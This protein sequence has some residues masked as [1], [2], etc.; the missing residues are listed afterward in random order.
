MKRIFITRVLFALMLLL[1][2][3]ARGQTITTVSITTPAA[4]PYC[5]GG[6]IE[7]RVNYSGFG[8]NSITKQFT[9]E[10]SDNAGNFPSSELF[11]ATTVS[12]THAS[13]LTTAKIT[14]L[15]TAT[16]SSNYKIRVT[17]ISPSSG[18]TG[19]SA[20]FSV[21]GNAPIGTASLVNNICSGGTFSHTLVADLSGTTF[22]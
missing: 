17:S 20:T 21:N 11:A 7:V 2:G 5:L 12:G 8:D 16:F 4:P 18:V 19:E 3:F 6:D 9:V 13:R 14:L 10:A 15:R 22:S 1:T